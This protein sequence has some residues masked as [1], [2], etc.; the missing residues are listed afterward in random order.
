MY[1][2][3]TSDGPLKRTLND[4]NRGKLRK[5]LREELYRPFYKDWQKAKD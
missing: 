4:S 2:F 3:V 5:M 1:K